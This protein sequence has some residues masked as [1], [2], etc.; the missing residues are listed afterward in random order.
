MKYVVKELIDKKNVTVFWHKGVAIGTMTLITKV[1]SGHFP[2]GPKVRKA[3]Q[4]IPAPSLLHRCQNPTFA[5]SLSGTEM[6]AKDAALQK[7]K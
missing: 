7:G 4:S 5:A 1:L 3:A 2:V 6:R